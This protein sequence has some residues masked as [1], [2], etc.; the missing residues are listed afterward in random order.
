MKG[1]CTSHWGVWRALSFSW[2]QCPQRN[3]RHKINSRNTFTLFQFEESTKRQHR[4]ILD[5]NKSNPLGELYGR[6]IG[7]TGQHLHQHCEQQII[8]LKYEWMNECICNMHYAAGNHNFYLF[9]IGLVLWD[10]HSL[11]PLCSG[12]NVRIVLEWCPCKVCFY[13]V[14]FLLCKLILYVITLMCLHLLLH[15]HFSTPSCHR[16]ATPGAACH[17]CT[18]T[19]VGDSR[20]M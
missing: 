2:K 20:G 14:F 16:M 4:I 12:Y 15:A 11:Q 6:H 18:P 9:L 7:S 1:I 19:S 8:T 17:D 13:F 10:T 5:R 3:L